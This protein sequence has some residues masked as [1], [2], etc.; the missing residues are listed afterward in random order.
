MGLP[1]SYAAS[2][3]KSGEA[4]PRQGSEQQ[5]VEIQRH[6][7]GR[8]G[9]GD[10]RGGRFER[11]ARAGGSTDSAV[12]GVFVRDGERIENAPSS[13]ADGRGG[14]T[15]ERTRRDPTSLMPAAARGT[16]RAVERIDAAL[17]PEFH[18]A[19]EARGSL[20]LIALAMLVVV[21]PEGARASIRRSSGIR[22]QSR[23]GGV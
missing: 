19:R 15:R 3:G 16:S 13:A 5:L 17:R 10:R 23:V 4:F 8:I 9:G 2:W 22:R 21:L 1:C 11:G 7:G 20:D 14:T 6:V 12:I 18:V